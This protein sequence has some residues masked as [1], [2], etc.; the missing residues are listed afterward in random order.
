VVEDNEINLIV[1]KGILKKVGVLPT[2]ANNGQEA[3]DIAMDNSFDLIL[4]DCEMPVMDGY[5]ATKS[6]RSSGS[7]N[8][9]TPIYAL[10]A[11]A[12]QEYRD[13]AFDV[14]MNGFIVKPIN[15]EELLSVV[16]ASGS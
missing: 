11:H 7:A 10:S 6:I 16:S 13:R 2:V 5:E 8:Q 1:I 9:N 15:R 4:M 14:G 12:L 3:C